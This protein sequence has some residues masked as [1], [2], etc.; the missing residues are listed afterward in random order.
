[1]VLKVFLAPGV[2]GNAERE[3]EPLGRLDDEGPPR[4]DGFPRMP[5]ERLL[6]LLEEGMPV[7]RGKLG[8]FVAASDMFE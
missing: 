1:M 2:P 5:K 6:P 4:L 8:P 3:E 7:V